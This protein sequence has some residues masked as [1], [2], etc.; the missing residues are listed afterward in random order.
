MSVADLVLALGLVLVIEGLVLVLAPARI[1]QALDLLR[2]LPVES[3]RTLGLAAVAA[4][5]GVAWLAV[6]LAA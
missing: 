3:R 4:G 6:R 1:D 5:V 2:S